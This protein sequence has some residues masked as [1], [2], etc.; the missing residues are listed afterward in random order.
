[1]DLEI[2]TQKENKVLQRQQI[3]LKAKDGKLTPSRK[4]L[5]P[6]IAAMLN[7]KEELTVIKKIQHSF[8]KREAL[9]EA[10]VYENEEALK[11]AE[12]KHLIERD[13]GKKKEKGKE[14]PV[15]KEVKPVEGKE[16]P[17][18]TEKHA[19]KKGKEKM[20]GKEDEGKEKPK[21]A[22]KPA[23][24]KREEK[25]ESKPV[26][27]KEKRGEEKHADERKGAEQ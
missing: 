19:D 18:E 5:R 14:K 22:E 11:R 6:K 13:S 10:N 17:K 24:E 16:K 2:V 1:M 9:I 7:A 12:Q 27:E 4:E 3:V 15:E 20:E 23:G 8:G 21:E 26:E 25:K